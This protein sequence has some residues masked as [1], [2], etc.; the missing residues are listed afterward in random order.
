MKQKKIRSDLILLIFIIVWTIAFSAFFLWIMKSDKPDLEKLLI[1]ANIDFI[2]LF[3]PLIPSPFIFYLLYRYNKAKG[4]GNPLSL[5]AMRES[6]KHI[7]DTI[8][9][10][11][12]LTYKEKK[13]PLDESKLETLKNN[14]IWLSK[15]SELNDPF[16][17]QMFML[18]EKDFSRNYLPN[19]IK[20]EYGVKNIEE[21]E[22][23]LSERRNK[24]CQASFS[25]NFSDVQMWGYYAN[26][27]RG[28]C[29]EYK[30]LSK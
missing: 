19:E 24:Y 2:V 29:V 27:C 9:K 3:F 20:L 25:K 7:P 4:E 8:Y 23:L 6:K 18:S 15:C 13:D 17:G 21:L 11:C 10:F 28:Y 30:V 26:G 12:S 5:E 16:E 1:I 14:E 22:S